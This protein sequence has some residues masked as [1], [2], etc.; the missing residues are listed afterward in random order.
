MLVEYDWIIWKIGELQIVDAVLQ[1]EV[2]LRA[3]ISGLWAEADRTISLP[4][5][6]WVTRGTLFPWSGRPTIG[7]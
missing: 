4:T 5:R 6:T 2:R 1:D 3:R 7:G